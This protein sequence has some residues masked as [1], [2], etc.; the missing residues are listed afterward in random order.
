MEDGFLHSYA[1]VLLKAGV[2]LQ[3]GKNLRVR[4]EPVHRDFMLVVA[5]EAYRA[6]ARTVKLDYTDQRHTR[7]RADFLDSAYVEY[8]PGHLELELQSY[9]DEEWAL[10]SLEGQEDP[11]ILSSA[12]AGKLAQMQQAASR[13]SHFFTQQLMANSLAW[14]VA[15][16]PTRKW[17]EKVLGP[18]APGSPDPEEGLWEILVPILRLDRDDPAAAWTENSALLGGRALALNRMGLVGLQFTGPGTDLTV[19]LM[20]RSRFIGGSAVTRKGVGFIPNIPTEEVFTTP[21]CRRTEGRLACTRPVEVM[22]VPVDGITLEFSDG[23]VTRFDA[24]SGREALERFLEI[25]PEARRLGEVA[26]VD[27][28]SPV[29][30]SGKV[31]HSIL[32]DENAASHVALGAGYPDAV[33][34]GEHM[35]EEEL[36]RLGCNVSL[37]HT[38]F[39][40][41]G[42]EVSV[43]GIQADGGRREI[44]RKGAFFLP[45]RP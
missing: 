19:G 20:P 36:G 9:L 27:A 25:D 1:R 44:I 34:G 33:D 21:D 11:D 8:V 2:N 6:G 3:P 31:F 41:G 29:A 40:I 39:M 43:S 15:P 23:S 5:E 12:D 30:L 4:G 14:C 32:F 22:G 28:S 10:L 26:L 18:A 7:I 24:R 42:P 37:V 16:V 13:K 38:D 17:A 35:S 45:P